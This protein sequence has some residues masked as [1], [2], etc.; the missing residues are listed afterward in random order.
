MHILKLFH[1]VPSAGPDKPV[2]AETYDEI[3]FNE[4]PADP[5]YRAALQ[6]GPVV[7]PPPY[8]HGEHLGLFSADAD[9]IAIRAARQFILDR[10]EEQEDRLS[11]ARASAAVL[12]KQLPQLGVLF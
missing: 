8:P 6:K 3:V 9:L 1:D 11:K 12:K 10:L 4:L 5:A 7:D 2:V